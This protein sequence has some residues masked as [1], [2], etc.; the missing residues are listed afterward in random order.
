M[1]VTFSFASVMG[2]LFCQI[3]NAKTQRVIRE[4]KT[5]HKRDALRFAKHLGHTWNP[6]D[7]IIP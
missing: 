3:R 1:K 6:I 5:H 7:G 4:I 2:H